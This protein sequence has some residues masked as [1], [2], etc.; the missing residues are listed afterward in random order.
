MPFPP[1]SVANTEKSYEHKILYG[2]RT[3]AVIKKYGTI[4]VPYF[5]CFF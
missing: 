4:F 1:T 3:A 2:K 5:L